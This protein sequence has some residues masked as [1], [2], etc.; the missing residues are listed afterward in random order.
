MRELA[1]QLS[2]QAALASLQFFRGR[3]GSRI[4][5]FLYE[6]CI[7]AC[8]ASFAPE[9]AMHILELMDE[10]G[11]TASDRVLNMLMAACC[12]GGFVDTAAEV[13]TNY[14]LEL[15]GCMH[16]RAVQDVMQCHAAA[17]HAMSCAF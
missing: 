2:A 3:F 11:K 16:A 1:S 6:A 9:E 7:S 10:D 14:V 8:T 12:N 17:L 15:C 13:C 5:H 4:H